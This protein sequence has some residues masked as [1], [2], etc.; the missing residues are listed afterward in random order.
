[1]KSDRKNSWEGRKMDRSTGKGWKVKGLRREIGKLYD[2]V[3]NNNNK[4]PG[5]DTTRS[6][7]FW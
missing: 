2:E 6:S 5:T 4:T 3:N 7:V 1:M